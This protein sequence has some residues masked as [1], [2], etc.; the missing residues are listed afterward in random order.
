ML[1]NCFCRCVI[2]CFIMLG[3]VGYSWCFFAFPTTATLIQVQTSSTFVIEWSKSLY[4]T[5]CQNIRTTPFRKKITTNFKRVAYFLYRVC[6]NTC[7]NN[8]LSIL[9]QMCAIVS[10]IMPFFVFCFLNFV[11]FISWTA[12]HVGFSLCSDKYSIPW[13]ASVSLYFFMSC[14]M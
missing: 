11:Q 12:F 14:G 4:T 5:V 13:I 6:P 9:P 1:F 3:K 2:S 8:F 10:N 7:K